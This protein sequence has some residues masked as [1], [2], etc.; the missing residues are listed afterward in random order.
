MNTD[1]IPNFV[2]PFSGRSYF[3]FI[4]PATDMSS[5]TSSLGRYSTKTEAADIP[6]K[7]FRF[8]S[9]L[10]LKGKTPHDSKAEAMFFFASSLTISVVNTAGKKGIYIVSAF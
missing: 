9:F 5:E 7:R 3:L 6:W 1:R 10:T 4:A 2:N 8:L